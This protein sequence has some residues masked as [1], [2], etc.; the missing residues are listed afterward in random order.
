M[1]REDIELKVKV[2]VSERKKMRECKT[3]SLGDAGLQIELSTIWITKPSKLDH[4]FRTDLNLTT[5]IVSSIT[6]SILF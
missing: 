6:I 4:R 3:V 1:E 2:L 5:K